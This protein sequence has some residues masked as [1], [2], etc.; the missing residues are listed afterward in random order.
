[1][2]VTITYEVPTNVIEELI[3]DAEKYAFDENTDCDEATDYILDLLDE[4][5]AE[6]I[7]YNHYDDLTVDAIYN[8]LYERDKNKKE[9]K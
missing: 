9:K 2:K 3:E 8:L 5:I 4:Y 6:N 7:N 1:M